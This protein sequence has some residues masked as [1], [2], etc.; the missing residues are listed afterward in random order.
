MITIALAGVDN[1]PAD[2]VKNFVIMLTF[3]AGLYFAHKRG[4]RASGTKSDPVSIAQPLEIKHTAC[5][6]HR[7]EVEKVNLEVKRIM[8][9]GDGRQEK[10]INAIGATER[11]LMGE[12]KDLHNRLN[13]V[14]ESCRSHTDVLKQINDRLS[15]HERLRQEETQRIHQRIDDA[16][17]LSS[18]KK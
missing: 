7:E 16:I 17:R 9:A 1:V 6:A 15:N 12:V 3:L 18:A 14:A 13:P 2:Y 11:R 4:M 5:Y 8:D 10:I